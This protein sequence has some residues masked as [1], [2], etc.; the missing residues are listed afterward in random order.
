[1]P[2]KNYSPVVPIVA[3]RQRV[4]HM[5]NLKNC[6]LNNTDLISMP[7]HSILYPLHLTEFT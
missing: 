3:L 1:M 4:N 5:A 7:A 2:N 6:N